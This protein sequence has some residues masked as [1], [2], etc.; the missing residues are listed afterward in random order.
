M[1]KLAFKRNFCQI[2]FKKKP[3]FKNRRSINS[4]TKLKYPYYFFI[5]Y[6][7]SYYRFLHSIMIINIKHTTREKMIASC[8]WTEF[9]ILI[10]AFGVQHWDLEFLASMAKVK[11]KDWNFATI[12]FFLMFL[13]ERATFIKNK[14]VIT[15]L[16]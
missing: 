9:W 5:L 3:Q 4:P 15:S 7:H 14:R 2:N 12:F 10:L 6:F 11:L 13:I 8:I 16:I 1:S